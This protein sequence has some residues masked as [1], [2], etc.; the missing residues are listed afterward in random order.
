MGLFVPAF[1]LEGRVRRGGLGSTGDDY[2]FPCCAGAGGGTGNFLK[3]GD[4]LEAALVWDGGD[5]LLAERREAALG[6][7]GG[8]G[9]GGH[10]VYMKIEVRRRVELVIRG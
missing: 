5:E 3:L 6:D 2:D 10:G 7:G 1:V 4:V 8:G 9:S